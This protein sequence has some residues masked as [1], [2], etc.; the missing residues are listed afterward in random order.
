MVADRAQVIREV[1]LVL[2]AGQRLDT[3]T[4]SRRLGISRATL[5]RR[6]G[7]REAL[8]GEALWLLADSTLRHYDREHDGP[9]VLP[10]GRLRCLAVME[11]F[12]R[13]TATSLPIQSLLADEPALAIRVLTDPRGRV[14]PRV[15][16][17]YQALLSRDLE[18]AGLAPRVPLPLLCFAQLRLGESFVYAD[19]LASREV[20]LEAATTVLDAMVM[21][22]VEP[23][24]AV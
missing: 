24:P 16:E 1:A 20:D 4:L 23:S 19:V 9:A 10:D 11:D 15:V 17:A 8:L 5:F 18:A 7:S 13:V 21:S 22:L 2:L 14:Q 6:V 3:G 12:R